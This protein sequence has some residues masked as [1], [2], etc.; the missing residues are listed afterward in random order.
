[1][2][3]KYALSEAQQA[4]LSN[5]DVGLLPSTGA[6]SKYLK[7]SLSVVR[8]T[9]GGIESVITVLAVK[10]GVIPPT[11]NLDHPDDDFDLDFAANA[12]QERPLKY[13]LNNSFGFG[14]HNVSLAFRRF[15]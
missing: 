6:V 4:G 11:I 5:L 1:M 2:F 14:G 7:P 3:A 8:R 9:Q 15:E 12:V 13:A 10:N